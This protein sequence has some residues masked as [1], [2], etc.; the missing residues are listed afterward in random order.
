[1]GSL[2]F[3]RV[4]SRLRQEKAATIFVTN[5]PNLP[6][7][8]DKVILMGPRDGPV[9]SPQCSNILAMGTYDE[10]V[11][12]GYDLS[13]IVDTDE[14]GV[15][16]KE[17]IKEYEIRGDGDGAASKA[18][19]ARANSNY[20]DEAFPEED[21]VSQIPRPMVEN[22]RQ[23]RNVEVEGKDISSSTSVGTTTDQIE[24]KAA[25]MISTDDSMSTGAVPISTYVTYFKSV[26]QP[27]L[28]VGA[29]LAYF[30]SNGAQ[31][32]QQFVIAKWTELGTG[33]A[34]VSALGAK[35]LERLVW[36]AGVVSG[37]LWLRS[38]LTMRLGVRASKVLHSK[39][40]S[41]VF[42]APL[43][44][45]S[46]TPSGQILTRFGKELEVVDR[47]LPDGIASVL[48]CFLQ[49]L[50]SGAALAGIVTPAMIV[51]LG[52]VGILYFKTMG[53]FRPA[54]RDLKRCESK[55]RAP[56]YTHFREAVRG[57]ETI[58][59]FP[60]GSSFWANTHRRLTDENLSVFY[61]VKALDR[62]L[63]IRLETLGNVIVFAAAV[64]SVYLTR[65]GRL[66]VSCRGCFAFFLSN[67]FLRD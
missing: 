15:S 67:T 41:S 29:L 63:S 51:P 44:F 16:D 32:F 38:Y 18:L 26:K 17:N 47:S 6:R 50:F 20:Q 12:Q 36:A 11:D 23:R 65:M 61:S 30:M 64:A 22:N 19:H 24:P 21:Y 13:S 28:V 33:D 35:Y 56:I 66:K 5:D 48:F 25:T 37:F 52:L 31:F 3:D 40:L 42:R 46:A 53:R 10:L 60:S 9:G 14:D 27:V 54:A 8:C 34:M 39:M 58:R 2:V 43:S 45:F 4:T 57:V 49:I 55:S 62:W 7:R 1:M 59:S